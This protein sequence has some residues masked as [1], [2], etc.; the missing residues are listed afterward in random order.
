MKAEITISGT[1]QI[2]NDHNLINKDDANQVC[3]IIT[4]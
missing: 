1:K 4:T 3:N 2:K